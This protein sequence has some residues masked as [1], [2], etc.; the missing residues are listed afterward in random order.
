MAAVFLAPLLFVGYDSIVGPDGPTAAFYRELVSRPLYY[1]VLENTVEISV[2]ATL[3]TLL[4]GYPIAYHLSRQ[5]P[6]RRALFTILVLL[7][8]W[9]SILVKSFAFTILLGR[10]GI[11]NGMLA[12]VGLPPLALLFN[13]LGVMI[14]LTHY[15]LPF[16][17]FAILPSLLAQPPEL[18]RAAEVM[19]AG[20]LRIFCRITLPLSVPGVMAGVLLCLI[21][22]MGS[23]VIPA[24]LGGRTDLMIAN[25][26]D[27]DVH[28]TL[29]WNEASAI[30][31]VL[32]VL[33]G[34][35]T[36]LLG[37]VRGAE[38]LGGGR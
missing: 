3:C 16:M 23:F 5:S 12:R 26:I 19:G 22:G 25:L 9:T 11:L 18:R 15:L 7:P 1:R 21:L 30:A 33:T 38:L 17:V 20:S 13:R 29:D 14:G 6:R 28:E 8:F 35:F 10:A 24:L 4:V 2:L 32:V 31:A 34:I 27:F 37:R 36:L